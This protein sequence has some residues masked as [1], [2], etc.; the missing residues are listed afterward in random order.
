MHFSCLYALVMLYMYLD[1]VLISR[2]ISFKNVFISTT[3]QSN[4][5]TRRDKFDESGGGDNNKCK[6]N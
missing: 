5:M 2:L 1:L 4:S 6:S 3:L